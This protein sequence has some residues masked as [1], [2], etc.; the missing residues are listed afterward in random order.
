[1]P[2]AATAGN[3]QQPG[4]LA[5]GLATGTKKRN[6]AR[7]DRERRHSIAPTT[8]A[9]TNIQPALEVQLLFCRRIF[10]TAQH[11]EM[12]LQP[13]RGGRFVLRPDAAAAKPAIGFQR[14]LASATRH[15]QSDRS[16]LFVSRLGG[17]QRPDIHRPRRVESPWKIRARIASP[18]AGLV[19]GFFGFN[20]VDPATGIH[21][22][23]DTE[24]LGNDAAAGRN[25]VNTNVYSNDPPGSGHPA[26]CPGQRS[27]GVSHL[28]H[29]MVC[30]P[31]AMVRRWPVRARGQAHVPQG[32]LALRLNIWAPDATWA[33]AYSAS[34]QP[35]SSVA[36][37]TLLLRGRRLRAGRAIG[38]VA[39]PTTTGGRFVISSSLGTDRPR[40]QQRGAPGLSHP[41][42]RRLQHRGF[43]QRARRS[44]GVPSPDAG[45]QSSIADPGGTLDSGF[46]TGTDLR[47]TTGNFLLVELGDRRR[48]AE[49]VQDHPGQRQPDRGRRPVR[50]PG[51]RRPASR[52]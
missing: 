30:R 21:N 39:E 16:R 48:G 45:F 51:R 3:R 43:H 33:D 19:G 23:L 17:D 7:F 9:L 52:S 8:L 42:G 11:G 27:H 2:A 12:G 10:I 24:L 22:E 41:A 25:Q 1:M 46:L 29:G 4:T 44:A 38:A 49:P 47:L 13:F 5:R 28:S 6:E 18:V 31:G 35:A 34:L 26:F 37:N 50:H 32:A 14:R 36:A 15:V 20:L 40:H